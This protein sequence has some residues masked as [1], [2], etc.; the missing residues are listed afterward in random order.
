MRWVTVEDLDDLAVGAALL[1]AGGGGD[2][3]LG[4]LMAKQVM[5]EKGPVRL[6]R[7]EELP[8]AGIVLPVAMMGAPTVSVEKIPS[9]QEWDTVVRLAKSFLKDDIVALM[10]AE[11]GGENSFVPLIAAAMLNLPVL[12][13]DGMGR[14]FPEIPMTSMNL[15]GVPA[16]P[17]AMADERGN[18]VVVDA[19]DNAWAERISRMI[20]VMMGGSAAIALYAM[21]TKAVRSAVVEG[22]LSQ[23]I[24][25]GRWLRSLAQGKMSFDAFSQATGGIPLFQ[26]KVVDVIRRTEGGFVRGTATIVGF[27]RD[28]GSVMRVEFQNEHL[29]AMRDGEPVA[30]VPDIIALLD[31]ET[32]MPITTESIAYG[33]RVMVFGLPCAPLWRTQAGLELVGP[34][35]FGYAFDYIPIDEVD[36]HGLSTGN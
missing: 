19:V 35:R 4:K 18:R 7:V 15:S 26:G 24:R 20:T 17:M 22:S 3:H 25:Y 27:D 34:R 21:E 12:D 9:G 28:D 11:I 10:S 32:F 1:G 23:T 29:V 8:Q 6:I 30:M 36:R 33:Q 31:A 14:A 2:P 5:K 13:A 16:A